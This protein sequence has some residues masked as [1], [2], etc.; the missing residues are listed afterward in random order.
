MALFRAAEDV[1]VR[2]DA[3][4]EDL[5]EKLRAAE[6]EDNLDRVRTF[7]DVAAEF[8]GLASD[9]KAAQIVRRRVAAAA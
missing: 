9:D 8:M 1:Q 2:L 5:L 7:L 3:Y 6:E 4:V